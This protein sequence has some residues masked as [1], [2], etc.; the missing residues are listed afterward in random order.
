M[1][2]SN[3]HMRLLIWC[4]VILIQSFV[5]LYSQPGSFKNTWREAPRYIPNNT[6]IDAPLMGNGNI[7]MSVGWKGNCLR[8][9]LS[10]N[11]FWRLRSQADN[12]SGPRVA[13]FVDIN[14]EDFTNADFYAEQNISDGIT[15]CRLSDGKRGGINAVSWVSATENLAIY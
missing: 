7:T 10:K 12:L 9:Y 6:S 8:Y 5:T 4:L 15:S 11:D 13:G 3:R 2:K 1:K 14:I